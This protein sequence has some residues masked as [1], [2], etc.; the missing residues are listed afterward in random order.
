MS[1]LQR[2]PS[3]NHLCAFT[4]ARAPSTRTDPPLMLGIH[5]TYTAETTRLAD[6]TGGT[7]RV[8]GRHGEAWLCARL[9]TRL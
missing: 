5:R 1:G 2:L 6:E 9:W 7:R 8:E 3:C 4:V